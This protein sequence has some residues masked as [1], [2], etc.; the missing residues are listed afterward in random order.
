[1]L[2]EDEA[3]EKAKQSALDSFDEMGLETASE[4]FQQEILA[5]FCN[6]D[7]EMDARESNLSYAA[8][9]ASEGD[10]SYGT[11]LIQECDEKGLL[12]E[13]DGIAVVE[14]ENNGD[15]AY[16]SSEGNPVE[17]I[18]DAK[19]FLMSDDADAF[20]DEILGDKDISYKV[21][22]HTDLCDVDDLVEKLADEMNDNYSS[23]EDYFENMYGSNWMHEVKDLLKDFI[24]WDAAAQEC[25]DID[26]RGQALATYDGDENEQEVNGTTYYIYRTN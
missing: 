24:D 19:R 21:E 7:W 14:F 18:Q 26:G 23:M 16:L 2:T 22:F 15:T 13:D 10:A 12:S 5:D 3:D 11:R 20:A 9:I 4:S 25:V 1:M 6:Y 8:D 17:D